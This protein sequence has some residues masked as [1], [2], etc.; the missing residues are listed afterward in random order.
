MTATVP[1]IQVV[2]PPALTDDQKLY[3]QLTRPLMAR[4]IEWR[5]QR[6]G[7]KKDRSD[8]DQAWATLTPYVTARGVQR[9]LDAVF[10]PMGWQ[11]KHEA[12]VLPTPGVL[13]SIGCTHPSFP[14]GGW[15]W[16]ADAA[17]QTDIEEVKG[18]ISGA[19]KRAAVQW[20]IGRWLYDLDEV[21]AEITMQRPDRDDHSGW[22]WAKAKRSKS[23]SEGVEFWWKVPALALQKV[24]KGSDEVE[25]VHLRAQL[26]ETQERL[27]QA[28]AELDPVVK[29]QRLGMAK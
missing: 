15:V 18:G 16:K 6:S 26:A 29:M 2:Q 5:V 4:D 23:D 13:T 21:F 25:A 17:E 10:G 8:K 9:R 22:E 14:A 20:G 7:V 24:T 1:Q 27:A 28:L 19:F 12:L 3:R 11:V